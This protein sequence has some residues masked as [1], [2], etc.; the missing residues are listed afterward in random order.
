MGAEILESQK[1]M[2]DAF[3]GKGTAS[4]A[5]LSVNPHDIVPFLDSYQQCHLGQFGD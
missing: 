3:K 5:H 1:E 2:R 4:H